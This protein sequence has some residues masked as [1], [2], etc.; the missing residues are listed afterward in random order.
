MSMALIACRVTPLGAVPGR[1]LF[2]RRDDVVALCWI[3]ADDDGGQSVSEWRRARRFDNGFGDIGT[4]GHFAQS[5]H[6]FIGVKANDEAVLR[7]VG[8]FTHLGQA[9]M[10]SLHTGDLHDRVS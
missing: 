10:Q 3:H 6:P 5:S 4:R 8:Y 7:A 9:H 1:A 2:H